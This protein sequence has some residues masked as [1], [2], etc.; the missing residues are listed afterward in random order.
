MNESLGNA[1]D[2]PAT[3]AAALVELIARDRGENRYMGWPEKL[4]VRINSLLPGLIDRALARQLRTIRD[5][6]RE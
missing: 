6:A 2:D 3:V 4:Y 1:T 5:F